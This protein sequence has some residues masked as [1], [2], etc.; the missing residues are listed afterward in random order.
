MC[1]LISFAVW[2]T[3]SFILMRQQTRS[4]PQL[5]LLAEGDFLSSFVLSQQTHTVGADGH[6]LNSPH[7][8]AGGGGAVA[9]V[10]R[11]DMVF[12]TDAR[13][14][15]EAA[16]SF[17]EIS[18]IEASRPDFRMDGTWSTDRRS[19][20]SSGP[21]READESSGTSVIAESSCCMKDLSSNESGMDAAPTRLRRKGSVT[22]RGLVYCHHFYR[23]VR[24]LSI[25]AAGIDLAGVAL[26]RLEVSANRLATPMPEWPISSTSQPGQAPG[27][28]SPPSSLHEATTAGPCSPSLKPYARSPSL[29]GR[30][31]E[32][33][34]G[35][36]PLPV[37]RAAPTGVHL[38]GEVTLR[39]ALKPVLIPS[40]D[41]ATGVPFVLNADGDDT[42]APRDADGDDTAAP[43]D[44][45]DDTAAV[46]EAG[47]RTN[48]QSQRR[49]WWR[50]WV[51][52]RKLR[53]GV[54]V[55]RRL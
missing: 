54:K 7:D 15:G 43:R 1:G 18:G 46:A 30:P 36:P 50:R 22:T 13:I 48:G 49:W 32:R 52:W 6:Q 51:W 21:A 23:A 42:A 34:P 27:E 47:A 39:D 33:N 44:A 41:L 35:G 5:S 19:L 37:W 40:Y 20:A 45:D 17:S 38:F 26:S 8:N 53:R 25:D 10:K 16:A 2:S 14:S 55:R 11:A 3:P 12:L 29:F 28:S 9:L 31:A 4:Y 24:V